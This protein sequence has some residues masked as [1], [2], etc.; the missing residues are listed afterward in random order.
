MEHHE[1]VTRHYDARAST[2]DAIDLHRALVATVADELEPLPR[3]GLVV[4]VATG[5]GLM[6]RALDGTWTGRRLGVDRSPGMLRVARTALPAD[7]GLARADAAALPLPDGAADLVT[8]VTAL[9]LLPRAAAALD[10][11]RRVLRPGGRLVTATFTRAGDGLPRDFERRHDDFRTVAQMAAVLA[12][13]GFAVERH[14]IWAFDGD[15][16]LIC[17]ATRNP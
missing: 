1:A 12:P 11:W 9:H 16:L 8:C 10:E 7:V 4:D 13:S 2:Y 17:S 5:T 14:R 3:G 15:E 6:L